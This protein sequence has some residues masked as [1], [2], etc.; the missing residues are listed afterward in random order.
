[1]Y[2]YGYWRGQD[3]DYVRSQECWE[4]S[5]FSFKILFFASF[6]MYMNRLTTL[7]WSSS[8]LPPQSIQTDSL[9]LLETIAFGCV[10]RP[11]LVQTGPFL[12]PLVLSVGDWWGLQWVCN[13]R[14]SPFPSVSL[15]RIRQGA[16]TFPLYNELAVVS[17]MIADH[18][19]FLDQKH[20]TLLF[21][22]WQTFWSPTCMSFLHSQ[23]P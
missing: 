20:R 9:S 3:K 4:F 17:W 2:L 5:G 22:A 12:R 19:N 23:P 8:F 7:P 18:R 15:V 10:L 11:H 6:C 16:E 21:M 1:M 14:G 13:W